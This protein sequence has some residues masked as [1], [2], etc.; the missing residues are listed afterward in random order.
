MIKKIIFC[1]FSLF[2]L[3]GCN[4]P[5]KTQCTLTE[6]DHTIEIVLEGSDSIEKITQKDTTNTLNMDEL[7]IQKWV[8]IISKN[9]NELKG[10][11]YRAKQGR[12][13]LIE[14][15]QIDTAKAKPEAYEMLGLDIDANKTKKVELKYKTTV[16]NLESN[17]FA[18]ST[19]K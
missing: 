19:V 17:G 2:L 16:K 13:E 4:T 3:T 5:H 6:N 14:T 8:D 9:Y 18:C 12:N 11:K 15:I 10:V 7:E 1:I